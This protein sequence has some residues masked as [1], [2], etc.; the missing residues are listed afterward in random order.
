LPE[1]LHHLPEPAQLYVVGPVDRWLRGDFDG[2][3]LQ[4]IEGDKDWN[5]FTAGIAAEWQ[6]SGAQS[7]MQ[8]ELSEQ[9]EAKVGPDGRSVIECVRRAVPV[10]GGRASQ[11]LDV[12]A[13]AGGKSLIL[14]FRTWASEFQARR[15]ELQ[16]WA[17]SL[18]YAGNARN[19]A[20]LGERLW[21]PLF[22][23]ALVGGVLL[24][25]YRRNRRGV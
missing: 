23:G 9:H 14:A 18:T 7:H 3:L 15:P 6:R 25:L 13:P 19:P 22:T 17:D 1:D 11:S 4:V 2:V 16:Q 8:Y 12:Y 24:W 10:A 20:G 21:T 5:E